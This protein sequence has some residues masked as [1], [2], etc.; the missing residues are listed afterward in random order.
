VEARNISH[1]TYTWARM[2]TDSGYCQW[3]KWNNLAWKVNRSAALQEIPCILRNLKFYY[4]I[5]N[6]LPPVPVL[7]QIKPVHALPQNFLN[8]YFILPPVLRSSKW[9]LSLTLPY[10]THLYTTPPP[11]FAHPTP[12]PFFLIRLHDICLVWSINYLVKIQARVI[13]KFMWYKKSAKYLAKLSL[14]YI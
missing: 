7:G 14:R 11:C 5:H 1:I 2:F 13:Q 10:Q 12:I 9:S 3:N 6:S 8:I 4:R